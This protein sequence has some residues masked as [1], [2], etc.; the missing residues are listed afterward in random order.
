[1]RRLLNALLADLRRDDLDREFDDEIEAHIAFSTEDFIRRGL[2]L[3]EAQR[4]ARTEFGS[5][6]ATKEAH[7][8]ARRWTWQWIDDTAA[9]L[10]YALRVLWKDWR[11]ATISV[12]MLSLGIGINTA[13]FSVAKAALFDGF[14]SVVENNRLVYISSTPIYY[15][16]VELWRLGAR[17]F[18]HL[19]LVMNEF[20]V[21]SDKEGS[22]ETCFTTVATP[23]LFALA[24]VRPKL[25]RD[26]LP[27]DGRPG[28]QPVV[29]ISYELWRRR[30][31]MD[32]AIVGRTVRL[33]GRPTLVRGVM[34]RG[35]SFPADQDLWVPLVPTEAALR[36]Q[37]GLGRY[38]VGR[39]APGVSV[40][41]ARTE[42]D[43]LERQLSLD[44]PRPDARL[45]PMVATFQEWFIG[46]RA[47]RLYKAVSAAAALVLLIMCANVANLFL[48]RA[49]GRSHE[50]SIRL[51]L[52][53]GPG[54]MIRQLIVES[55]LLVAL[56]ACAACLVA[57]ICV[58][59]Y[60]SIA[61]STT[62]GFAPV[63]RSGVDR[64]VLAYLM[65]VSIGVSL[66]IALA[67]AVHVRA[68]NLQ[69]ATGSGRTSAATFGRRLSNV[70]ITT[71]MVLAVGVVA[72]AGV[73]VHSLANVNRANV[74]VDTHDVLSMALSLYPRRTDYPTPEAKLEFYREVETRLRSLPGVTSVAFA[75]AAPTDPTWQMELETSGIAPPTQTSRPIAG[76]LTVS[77]AYF[78][79]LGAHVIA[80]RA[81]EA[82]DRF[83]AM[84]VAIVNKRFAIR[85]W[86]GEIGV[87]K[88]IRL[89]AGNVAA[90][91]GTAITPWLTVVGVVSDI[92]QNDQT[93]QEVEPLVY[94][95][96]RQW[97]GQ[98][99][100]GF[101]K[102]RV[103]PKMLTGPVTRAIYA[104]DPGLPVPALWPLDDRLARQLSFER[105]MTFLFVVF[106]TVALVVAS[107]G[108]YAIM[109]QSV[110]RRTRE[111]GIRL[112]LGAAARDLRILVFSETVGAVAAGLGLGL[113]VSL[114]TNRFLE[115]LLVGVS[116]FDPVAAAVA[117]VALL[118]AAS[119]GAWVPMTRVARVDPAVVL[120]YD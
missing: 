25:G 66:L 31:G 18:S 91:L 58:Y 115:S 26:F 75:S 96:D 71:Q 63:L 106:G 6:L 119:A 49:M 3:R 35:F 16:D 22:P 69:G 83:R 77:A 90:A 45:T 98:T 94:L 50:F 74:G 108:V 72:T 40:Q 112:A 120:R 29:I 109:S 52:G 37:T 84:P 36:R 76:V 85:T 60:S 97:P 5:P 62:G 9:D 68:G 43:T 81:F 82:S 21:L 79:T 67:A 4:R 13:V 30:F 117:S 54:R 28:A 7:R 65:G 23:G 64:V 86:P 10:R 110:Q 57:A 55:G 92:V 12:G 44:F 15:P 20:R 51:A 59:V 114:V 80:G 38:A 42:L 73:I 39:L 87:G 105:D 103:P 27:S 78:E 89:N 93:R 118:I 56:S 104:V 19:A 24:G 47:A 17:S 2:P 102:T 33:N 95:P 46:S 14:P 113:A 32:P 116:A 100:F 41:S 107:T 61:P 99:A 34:P 101:V 88:R 53:A 8:D 1:M 11:F 70:F 48:E 111:I